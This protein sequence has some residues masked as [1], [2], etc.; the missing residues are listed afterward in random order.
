MPSASAA[1]VPGRIPIHSSHWAAVRVRIGSMAITRA[2][3]SR[4]ARTNGQRWG[5][6]VS[7]LVPQSSTRSLSGTPSASAPMFAPTV[8]R[9]PIAPATAQ[10]VRSSLDA[11]SRWKNR[12]SIDAPCSMP[13]VPAYE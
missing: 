9:M 11:P 12:R 1:S 13:I 7:V 3:F 10:I 6:D 4:A 2:P 8:I 5:F